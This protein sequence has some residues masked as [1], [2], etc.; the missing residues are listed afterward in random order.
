MAQFFFLYL[1]AFL[2]WHKSFNFAVFCCWGEV[3]V[4][5]EP[6]KKER[7]RKTAKYWTM[8]V[9]VEREHS[10]FWNQCY[11]LIHFIANILSK[12]SVPV[13]CLFVFACFFFL[14]WQFFCIFLFSVYS[15]LLQGTETGSKDEHS[16]NK[17]QNTNFT[18]ATK[19]YACWLCVSNGTR[20]L[21]FLV[22]QKAKTITLHS[23]Q[24]GYVKS[25]KVAAPLSPN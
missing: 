10:V 17:L 1:C 23:I 6:P 15:S 19:F 24:V 25:Q 12:S 13:Y 11:V 3:V 8:A 2:T 18:K 22:R 20:S 5:S 16:K 14:L 9:R 7:I 21:S 4:P